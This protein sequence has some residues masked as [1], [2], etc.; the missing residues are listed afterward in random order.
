M[1]KNSLTT[2]IG[3]ETLAF[4]GFR[5]GLNTYVS[6][7][8]IATT[9]AS[10]LVNW[11][12]RKNG[13]VVTRPVA[14]QYSTTATTGSA[15]VTYIKEANIGGTLYTLLVDAN[16]KLYYLN[17]TLQTTAIGTLEGDATILSYNGAAL[18]LDGSYV[19]YMTGVSAIKIAYD[20]GSGTTGVQF[21]NL[22]L[23]QDTFLAVGNGTNTRAAQKFTSQVWDTGYTIPIV[24]MSAYLDKAGNPSGTVSAVLRKFS[25]GSS[26]A[27][28]TLCTCAEITAGVPAKFTATFTSADIT[29]EMSNNTAYYASIEYSGGGAGDYVKL[30]CYNCGSGG[31]SYYYDGSWKAD[32]AKNCV[33]SVSPGRPPKAK[34]GTVWNRRP[35]VAGD[36]SNEG[37]VW[38]GNLTY[39]DWSTTDGGGYISIIDEN[40]NNFEVGGVAAFYGNLYVFGVQAQPYLVKISGASPS[41]YTQEM[42]FQRP[43]AT[44]KTLTTTVN[45]MWY[46]TNE[47]ASPLSGVQ[48][49]G[50]L[51]TFFASDPVTNRFEDYWSSSTSIGDYY[52][53][54]GQFWLV[55]GSYHR[56]L[57]CHTKLPIQD[58]SGSGTR[59]PWSEYEFYRK[60]LSD[61]DTGK[62]TASGS[63]T[64]EYYYTTV[65]G[66]DPGITV[67]P[68]AI[69]LDGTLLVEGTMGSLTDHQWDYGDNDTL[70]FNTVYVRDASGD[71]DTTGVSIRSIL[72]PK[73]FGRTG[74]YF[75]IGGSDGYIYRL[76]RADYKDLSSIQIKPILHTSYVELPFGEAN[77]S[78]VQLL[79]SSTGGGSIHLD[80]YTN[81]AYGTPSADTTITIIVRDNLTVPELTMDV[82]DALFTID[83][84]SAVPL[85]QGVNFNARSL[86][87][88]INNITMS[89]YPIY[90][91][92]ILLKYRRLSY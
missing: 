13:S 81:G 75:L 57:V 80:Y 87:V 28:K 8:R 88:A 74:N 51:R 7:D 27:T 16:H 56:V 86:M 17:G 90:N 26:M 49:Y 83:P 1:F 14:L 25:D 30:M 61:D 12:V 85:Y 40:S 73:S 4:Q 72:I 54:D 36:S 39:L 10:K 6:A 47:G 45:D 65:A 64:N 33:M 41:A 20:A 63:G 29:T 58:V 53:E 18:I 37:V 11:M 5:H 15:A 89:G 55:L 35:F 48:E 24:T 77:F 19:K 2:Q 60:D 62:W 42:M 79:A 66:G 43:W 38:Y 34:F 32:A 82:E 50:D 46:S 91:D 68:D 22:A 3:Y 21:N 76:D 92:G 78:Q 44:H 31:L 59:Y 71:P 67:K 70:G 23:T 84:E 9:E 69:T 52:S